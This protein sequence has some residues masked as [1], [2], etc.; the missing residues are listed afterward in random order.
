[1]DLK[2][3]TVVTDRSWKR[4]ALAELADCLKVVSFTWTGLCA[5]VFALAGI[6]AAAGVGQG[7]RVGDRVEMRFS[8]DY[9]GTVEVSKDAFLHGCIMEPDGDGGSACQTRWLYEG[10]L[11]RYY[12]PAAERE[13]PD[14]LLLDACVFVEKDGACSCEP[15]WLE[16][17]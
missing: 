1:L 8:A 9:G 5:A 14:D 11:H 15:M 17:Y 16:K 2:K 7:D 6:L 4:V 12:V 13:Y 3:E 10:H